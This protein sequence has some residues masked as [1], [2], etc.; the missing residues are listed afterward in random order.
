M[1]LKKNNYRRFP[2]ISYRDL[3]NLKPGLDAHYTQYYIDTFEDE[4][5]FRVFVRL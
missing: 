1:K 4:G 3:K 2:L 5:R